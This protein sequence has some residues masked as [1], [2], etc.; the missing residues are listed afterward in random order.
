MKKIAM[1]I[2]LFTLTVPAV[3]QIIYKC[4]T[5]DGEPI[6]LQQSLCSDGTSSDNKGDM[7]VTVHEVK[8]LS[9]DEKN[10]IRAEE[11]FR[12]EVRKELEPTPPPTRTARILEFLNSPLGLWMLSSIVISG[13]GFLYANFSAQQA[14]VEANRTIERRLN[15]EIARRLQKFKK[16]LETTVEKNYEFNWYNTA[17]WSLNSSDN[18]VFIEFKLRTLSSLLLELEAVVPTAQQQS[19]DT[20]AQAILSYEDQISLSNSDMSVDEIKRKVD[21]ILVDFPSK[22]ALTRWNR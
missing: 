4:Q 7:G 17:L 13:L 20:A 16:L 11:I 18:P 21:C 9:D 6:Y 1:L 15:I 12:Q 5:S 3:G 14:K 19:I 2:Y 10:R 22:F 8:I